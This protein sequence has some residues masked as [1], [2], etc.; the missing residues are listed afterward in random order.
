[1]YKC[2]IFDNDI[3]VRDFIP[4]LDREMRPAMYDSVTG[5]LFYNKG[6]GVFII[7]PDKTT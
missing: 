3:L 2:K 1:M 6:T 5:K 4:V 7:G